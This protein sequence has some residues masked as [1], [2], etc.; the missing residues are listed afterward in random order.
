MGFAV[1]DTRGATLASTKTNAW[2]SYA[3]RAKSVP[4]RAHRHCK[5]CQ[6]QYLVGFTADK[7]RN[8]TLYIIKNATQSGG[9]FSIK[10]LR[11]HLQTARELRLHRQRA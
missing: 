10:A 7:H 11:L 3:H 6:R 8:C 2:R 4:V 5:Y 1:G 9:I